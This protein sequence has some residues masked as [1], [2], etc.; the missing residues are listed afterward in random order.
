[1]SEWKSLEA[2]L[3]VLASAPSEKET[4]VKEYVK[5][6]V[7]RVVKEA[8]DAA[9]AARDD[10]K[11]KFETRS[12][13]Q[14]EMLKSCHKAMRQIVD[15]MAEL[16]RTCPT[17]AVLAIRPICSEWSDE[18]AALAAKWADEIRTQMPDGPYVPAG[19]A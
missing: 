13:L 4:E 16:P 2:A 3:D 10:E 19:E 15:V 1:M 5:W 7:E 8:V 14:R 6:R 11:R 12:A 17:S 9:V 18:Y